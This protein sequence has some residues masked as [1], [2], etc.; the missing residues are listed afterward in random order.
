MKKV[1][2]I[3]AGLAGSYLATQLQTKC[4]VTLIT[5]GQKEDSNSMLAQGGIAAAL[6]PGDSPALHAEDTFAAGAA[7]NDRLAVAQLVSTGPK[8]LT[9]II[10]DGMPFDRHG[11]GTLDFGL[12][13]AHTLHRVLHADGDRTGAALT[14]F[15]QGELSPKVHWRTQTAAISLDVRE[16]HCYGLIIRSSRNNQQTYLPA[17][18]V[19]IATGGLG[20]LYDFTTNDATITGDGIAMAIRSGAQ[21]RDMAF[22]QF[23][24][25]LLTI[26]G[27]CY[28][29]ITEAI[30]GAGAVLV[31]EAGTK[32]M[33][34]IPGRDL[35]PRD[36]VAR[37]L[38]DWQ[39]KG[40]DLFLEISAVTDFT[41]RFPG[42]TENLDQHHVPFRQ[43]HLIPIQPG[44]HFMMGGIATD[45][46]AQTSI[47]HLYAVGEA[48]CNG[49]HG[50]NRL[51]SN[52]LLDCLVSS[53]KA[54]KTIL[55]LPQNQ[56]VVAPTFAPEPNESPNVP[57][58]TA[59][60][61]AAWRYLGV[62]RTHQG[63]LTLD[64]WLNTYDITI[65]QPWM[66]ETDALMR[67][68]LALCALK[69]AQAADA[70]PKSLGAHHWQSEKELSHS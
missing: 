7:H 1:V 66:I 57:E 22:V 5:K 27:Q 42:V 4:Q 39:F 63:L 54:A 69:I 15:V 53:A 32:I 68:N 31:D 56:S 18:A 49:V 47:A 52:S 59:L 36:V 35:A 28:G 61:D 45:L 60:Q 9:K 19:V 25:T 29:L 67:A 70:E 34:A 16:G 14:R 3:G 10:Q 43:N 26:G 8:L 20:N 12:E 46:N 58:L 44:A 17:D 13:G 21:L 40:H 64:N 37:A 41:T 33:A 51:A 30:R 23:H 38:K 2:I 11:D 24:P 62:S 50:A 48:A 6:D 55:D 65:K